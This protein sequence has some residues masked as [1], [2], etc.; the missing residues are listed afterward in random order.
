M[1]DARQATDDRPARLAA[2]L[3][4]PVAWAFLPLEGLP[5]FDA[6]K[7]VVLLAGA[8]LI[9]LRLAARRDAPRAPDGDPLLA[10]PLALAALAACVAVA[11]GP[12]GAVDGPLLAVGALAAARL[13]ARGAPEATFR[14]LARAASVAAAGAGIYALVQAA[15]LDPT[16]WGA[17]REVV[18]TFGNT[19]FAAEF[20][21]AALPLALALALTRGAGRGD[22]V[23]GAAAVALAGTHLVLA[24]SRIDLV[25]VGVALTVLALAG[26]EARGRR[27]LA[28]GLALG[29]GVAAV[30]LAWAFRAAALG[31]GAAFLGRSDTVRVRL[32]VWQACLAMLRGIGAWLPQTHPF[33]DLFPAFRDREE[34]VLSLGR[35]VD[36]PHNTF[37]ALAV[38]L[39]LVGL[40]VAV[41]CASRLW[42]RLRRPDAAQPA[43]RGALAACSAALLVSGLASSPLEH[44]ATALLGG[45]AWGA[46]IGIEPRE[47]VAALR[48]PGARRAADVV[49]SAALFAALVGAVATLR[50]E[51]FLALARG[52]L[53]RGE[54]AQALRL[55]HDAADVDARAFAPRFELGV[56]LLNAREGRAAADALRAATA[57][58]PGSPTAHANLARA[59]LQGGD[60]AGGRA[61]LAR[62]LE[63]CP[64]HPDARSAAGQLALADGRARDAVA[65]FDE[66]LA[67]A[68][69]DPR[70]VALLA[71]ARL[72]A[73]ERNAHADA[74]AAL[75]SL[76]GAGDDAQVRRSTPAML[77]RDPEFVWALLHHAEALAPK[78]PERALTLVVAAGSVPA[79]QSDTGFLAAA[80]RVLRAAGR[81]AEATT[82]TGRLLGVRAAAALA[83]GDSAGA[84]RLAKQAVERDPDPEHYLVMAR[85]LARQ[86][87][88]RGAIDAIGSAVATGAVDPHAVRTDPD[89]GALLPDATLETLLERAAARQAGAAE[90]PR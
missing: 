5:G 14:A 33:T 9:T 43:A 46:A 77:R 22:R 55:L 71:E 86:G 65:D 66:A 56:L 88:R 30:A 3:L 72:A 83:V 68:P 90:A 58:R 21:A 25:A 37:L 23:L 70:L 85:A 27:R 44:G 74:L 40:A 36:T 78:A 19:S 50:G 80:A 28:R 62:A 12:V 48:T 69:N 87:Q 45:L 20:Q 59:L 35:E 41:L 2:W 1:S 82:F 39:G 81:E 53:A 11:A 79:L 76:F 89:L 34:F 26:L 8:A 32:L 16:P 7:L 52:H 73:R 67:S 61:A 29:A 4:V 17:R 6:L 18:A 38:P 51:T 84:L 49:V 60:D 57:L 24:R 31:D 42:R 47:P 63:L 10:V 13:T 54:H 15:G 64:W 75:D